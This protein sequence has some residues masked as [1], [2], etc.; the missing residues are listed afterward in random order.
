MPEE[1]GHIPDGFY[2]SQQEIDDLRKSKKE[3]TEYGKQKL[4]ELAKKNILQ[5]NEALKELKDDE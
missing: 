5:Y 4:R 3:L 2:L 1:Y